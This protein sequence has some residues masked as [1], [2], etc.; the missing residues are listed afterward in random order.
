MLDNTKTD[1]PSRLA[2]LTKGVDGE[3]R[4]APIPDCV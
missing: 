2:S 1:A 3:G 4:S